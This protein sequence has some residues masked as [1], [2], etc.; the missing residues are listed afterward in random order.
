MQ[1]VDLYYAHNPVT[2]TIAYIFVNTKCRGLPYKDADA[3]GRQAEAIFRNVLK[4]H[5]VEVFKNLDKAEVIEK[6]D[7]LWKKAEIFELKK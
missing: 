7:H 1:P 3:R 4:F 5:Q 6:L 2:E